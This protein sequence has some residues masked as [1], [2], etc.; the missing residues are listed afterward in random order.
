MK[1]LESPRERPPQLSPDEFASGWAAFAD[2]F[3]DEHRV[4]VGH[5]GKIGPDPRSLRLAIAGHSALQRLVELLRGIHDDIGDSHGGVVIEASLDANSVRES[6]EGSGSFY[7]WA[8]VSVEFAEGESGDAPEEPL[9]SAMTNAARVH[10]AAE[11]MTA[12]ELAS[13][14]VGAPAPPSMHVRDVTS[15]LRPLAAAVMGHRIPVLD[16]WRE[17]RHATLKVAAQ[18]IQEVRWLGDAVARIHP[19]LLDKRSNAVLAR[20]KILWQPEARSIPRHCLG[21]QEIEIELEDT[22]TPGCLQT[23]DLADATQAVLDDDDSVP[24]R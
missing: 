16:A 10:A 3:T 22:A 5:Y 18:G 17:K 1:S 20:G 24:F 21:W 2:A 13:M 15:D 12:R 23:V 14:N 4:V 9:L 11:R 8:F 6:R 7:E 19:Q